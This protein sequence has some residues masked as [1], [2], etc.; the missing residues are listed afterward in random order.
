MKDGAWGK[1]HKKNSREWR[2]TETLISKNPVLRKARD[3]SEGFKP[4]SGISTGAVDQ[5]YKDNYDQIDFSKKDD[6]KR[7]Y[8]VKING[9]YV[10]EEE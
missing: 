8:R 6:R 3:I 4:G 5:Q 7:N 9:R 1:G 10:D 2:K